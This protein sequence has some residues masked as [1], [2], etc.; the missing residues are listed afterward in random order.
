MIGQFA[1]HCFSSVHAAWLDRL[2][3]TDG[4]FK[5][6][7]LLTELESTRGRRKQDQH[8]SS[9]ANPLSK[10]QRPDFDAQRQPNRGS[11]ESVSL[12]ELLMALKLHRREAGEEAEQA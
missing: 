5:H 3:S 12:P 7:L 10:Q 2:Q 4:R 9:T 8:R 11:I 6:A 1:F